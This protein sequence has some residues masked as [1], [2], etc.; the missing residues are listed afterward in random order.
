MK[1]R[2]WTKD[3]NY[4]LG[5]G[6]PPGSDEDVSD[7]GIVQGHAYSIL[8]ACD[9]DGVKLL[10]L[11]NPWGNSKE[12]K[13]PWSDNSAEW[14]ERSRMIIY[15]H[16]QMKALEYNKIGK[17]DGIFWISL[18]DFVVNFRTLYVCQVFDSSY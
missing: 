5:A 11:R 1:F 18:E 17:D 8:D 7:L 9:V 3:D 16:M 6:T 10:Q 2:Q 14:T 12:W 4:L 15:R 13:G